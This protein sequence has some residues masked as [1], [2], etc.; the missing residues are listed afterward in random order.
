MRYSMPKRTLLVK[1]YIC[2]L[3]T[4]A[5]IFFS[6]CYFFFGFFFFRAQLILPSKLNQLRIHSI[7]HT[8]VPTVFKDSLGWYLNSMHS[9]SIKKILWII[10]AALVSTDAYIFTVLP[11]W[12]GM[13]NDITH[14]RCTQSITVPILPY[15]TPMFFRFLHQANS[16]NLKMFKINMKLKSH[17]FY[18]LDLYV[19][20]NFTDLQGFPI[21]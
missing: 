19:L 12:N 15:A 11:H 6:S 21:T 2:A 7:E 9:V 5:C 17:T 3:R 20:D 1:Q 18:S 10:L 4:N 8:P 13:L 14:L 16:E